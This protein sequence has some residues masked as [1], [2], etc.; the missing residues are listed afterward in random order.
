[1]NRQAVALAADSAVTVQG[2]G[3]RKAWQS[4]S[5][6]FG[7]S[8]DHPVGFMIYGS[9]EFM[10]IPWETLIKMYRDQLGSAQ[11]PHIAD[12]REDFLEYLQSRPTLFPEEE[13]VAAFARKL[14]W[15]YQH[16]VLRDIKQAAEKRLVESP[17]Q[18]ITESE[19]GEIVSR[20]VRANQ[21]WLESLDQAADIGTT[22][23][24]TLRDRYKSIV[25]Q[26]K[27]SVFQDWRLSSADSR[28]LTTIAW[29][30]FERLKLSPNYSGVVVAGYGKDEIFP[31]L[32]S[33][34]LDVFVG[35]RLNFDRGDDQSITRDN[36]AAVLAFAA[37]QDDVH[38][39]MEGV[40]SDYLS[41][42]NDLVDQLTQHYPEAIVDAV[43]NL[44][45][46]QASKLKA[47]FAKAAAAT[48]ANFIS[49]LEGYRAQ[50]FVKPVVD[51]VTVLPKD[52]LAEMAATLVNLS[53]FRH[54]L[55]MQVE[56]VGGPVDV[57][58]ISKGDG[59]VWISRKNYFDLLTNAHF[60]AK[61]LK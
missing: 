25:D 37:G 50:R 28:R 49:T 27:T 12:Y 1:M 38:A 53:S 33:A 40:H 55:S 8:S 9:A 54:K 56:S 34:R 14:R 22:L 43:P 45:S 10:Q 6:I 59:F 13:Q 15:F 58:V 5:K 30:L 35:G 32:A 18:P 52:E 42:V 21:V 60:I 19:F 57:A 41:A 7:L 36:G 20:W 3:G 26:V 48:H 23:R 46:A 61:Y 16:E 4:A 31:Q 47:A 24:R 11:L 29:L 17:T 2:A 39:F 44:K 51:V